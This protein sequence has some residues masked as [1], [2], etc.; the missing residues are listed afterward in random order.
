MRGGKKGDGDEK[1]KREEEKG[2]GGD[3]E[4]EREKETGEEEKRGEKGGGDNSRGQ[5]RSGVEQSG[6]ERRAVHTEK[7]LSGHCVRLVEDDAHLFLVALERIDAVLEFIRDVELV[8][9]KEKKDNVASV[10]ELADH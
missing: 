9:V 1:R 8:C 5:E 2:R 10:G 7:L 6:Q 3:E 4:S